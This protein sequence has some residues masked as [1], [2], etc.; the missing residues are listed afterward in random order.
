MAYISNL[1]DCTKLEIKL[2]HWMIKI[3]SSLKHQGE[4]IK[5]EFLKYTLLKVNRV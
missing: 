5:I 2:M 1:H 3:Q 4:S